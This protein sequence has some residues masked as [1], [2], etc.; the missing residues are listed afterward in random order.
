[1]WDVEQNGAQLWGTTD[2]KQRLGRPMAQLYAEVLSWRS[3]LRELGEKLEEE[4][5]PNWYDL[6]CTPGSPGSGMTTVLIRR[7]C[8]KVT[9]TSATR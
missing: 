7:K 8:G 2:Y 9:E 6:G 1:M 4:R 3:A 5:Q